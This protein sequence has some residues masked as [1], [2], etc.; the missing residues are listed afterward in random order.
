[1][2]FVVFFYLGLIIMTSFL[3]WNF[4]ESRKIRKIL[5]DKKSNPEAG[6]DKYLDLKY[7]IQLIITIGAILSFLIGYLGMDTRESLMK[8]SVEGIN[9][10][11][12][13]RVEL[14]STKK[15]L[16]STKRR[17]LM[18]DVLIDKIFDIKISALEK[19]LS[20][21]DADAETIRNEIDKLYEDIRIP[22]IYIFENM[23]LNSSGNNSKTVYF[24]SLPKAT[25][26][27]KL[28]ELNVAPSIL[29]PFKGSVVKI[30]KVTKDYF[31]YEHNMNIANTTTNNYDLWLITYE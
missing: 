28:P 18:I 24:S 27:L 13:L 25:N 4:F 31:I 20:K 21:M 7:Q 19:S 6:F 1:M 23:K 17:V 11:K 30:L 3:I 9:E 22:K 15:S 14:D 16:D 29:V 8:Q 10:I 26:G 2:D 5:V 12:E